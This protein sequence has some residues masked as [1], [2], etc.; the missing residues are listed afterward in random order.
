MGFNYFGRKNTP[1]DAR[2]IIIQR[3]GYGDNWYKQRAKALKRDDYTCQKCGKKGVKKN[4]RWDVHVHHKRKIAW[5]A[6]TSSGEVDY[7][8]ANDLENLITLCQTCHKV[9]DGHAKMDTFL[10]LK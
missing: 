3:K 6:N 8:R 1:K 5:F 10:Y 7:E 4:R 2:R 9:A